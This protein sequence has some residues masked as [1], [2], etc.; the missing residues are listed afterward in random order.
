ML[1]IAAYITVIYTFFTFAVVC[2]LIISWATTIDAFTCWSKEIPTAAVF[3]RITVIT[4]ITT[5]GALKAESIHVVVFRWT[6]G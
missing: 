1:T 2:V 3:A 4:Y 6:V 5:I